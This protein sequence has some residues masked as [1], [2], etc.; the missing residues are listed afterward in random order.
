[1]GSDSAVVY[2]DCTCC[3]QLLA[4]EPQSVWHQ[5]GSHHHQGSMQTK[6]AGSV[7]GV[8]C[9]AACQCTWG[10]AQQL[11]ECSSTPT[12][13]SDIVAGSCIGLAAV[14]H[15][16]GHQPDSLLITLLSVR[17]CVPKL[18]PQLR[19]E[20]CIPVGPIFTGAMVVMVEV[21]RGCAVGPA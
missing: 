7:H 10:R 17:A 11:I 20:K 21:C 4:G 8:C 9:C 15:C 5:G 1:V 2:I 18:H 12:C 13:C 6:G 3:L 16:L 14:T 19:V